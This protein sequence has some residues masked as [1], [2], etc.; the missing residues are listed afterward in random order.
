M[1]HCMAFHKI[2]FL[3][4]IN[5]YD[6]PSVKEQIKKTFYFHDRL[7]WRVKSSLLF[8]DHSNGMVNTTYRWR[9][10]RGEK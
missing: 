3:H 4:S 6:G 5:L 7:L 10:E 8:T 1:Y 2:N 9:G